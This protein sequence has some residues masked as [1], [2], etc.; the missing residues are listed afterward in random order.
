[1]YTILTLIINFKWNACKKWTPSIKLV[2]ILTQCRYTNIA[3]RIFKYSDIQYAS[4]TPDK[5]LNSLMYRTLFCVNIYGSYRLL[6]TV[7]FFW[8]TL[9]IKVKLE[10]SLCL[11]SDRPKVPRMQQGM[12]SSACKIWESHW[13]A[14]TLPWTQWGLTAIP[15]W[16]GGAS[17]SFPIISSRFRPFGPHSATIRALLNP[18]MI[19]SCL[20]HCR[21]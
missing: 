10:V 2:V 4:L 3:Q 1:M 19:K 17:C 7:R 14:G 5:T 8:P 12:S 20:R 6:K 9:Y 16:W 15:S 11:A 18:S 21:L 13:A